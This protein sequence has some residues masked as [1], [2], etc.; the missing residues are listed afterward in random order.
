[1]SKPNEELSFRKELNDYEK[2]IFIPVLIDQMETLLER[3]G[4][5]KTL[6]SSIKPLPTYQHAIRKLLEPQTTEASTRLANEYMDNVAKVAEESYII[7][8][9]ELLGNLRN[10]DTLKKLTSS[11]I[12]TNRICSSILSTKERLLVNSFRGMMIIINPAS[13][14]RELVQKDFNVILMAFDVIVSELVSIASATTNIINTWHEEQ[15]K[16]Q[17]A[18]LKLKNTKV[19][20]NNTKKAVY[21]NGL[22]VLLAFALSLLFL[23]SADPFGLW[24]RNRLLE[25]ELL[26]YEQENT[27]LKQPCPVVYKPNTKRNKK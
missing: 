6:T 10:T 23:I 9:R 2:D 7:P 21:L 24:K 14:E 25:K 15:I 3:F 1:M 8:L 18:S 22:V 17:T 26:K 16:S 11:L 5:L 20:Y 4:H 27:L 13:M 12:H 19:L